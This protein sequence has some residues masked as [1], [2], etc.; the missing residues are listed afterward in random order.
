[1]DNKVD[2]ERHERK[3]TKV[4]RKIIFRDFRVV[5]CFSWSPSVSHL[6]QLPSA[7]M[8]PPLPL[9]RRGGDYSLKYALDGKNSVYYY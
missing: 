3:A 7:E 2:H 1:M 4:T 6:A 8:Y 5:S 9:R